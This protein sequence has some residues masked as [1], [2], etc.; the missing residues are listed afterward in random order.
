MIFFPLVGQHRMPERDSEI[1]V[2]GRLSRG[3]IRVSGLVG[4]LEFTRRGA[5]WLF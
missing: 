1:Q 5:L 3:H 2:L 4:R